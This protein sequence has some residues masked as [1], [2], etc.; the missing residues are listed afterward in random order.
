MNDHVNVKID[1]SR[2][3]SQEGKELESN[4]VDEFVS[5][6]SKGGIGP[7]VNRIIAQIPTIMLGFV[8]H[9]PLIKPRKIKRLIKC[10]D[11]YSF[12]DPELLPSASHSCFTGTSIWLVGNDTNNCN[13]TSNSV[14]H[15]Q[16]C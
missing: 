3:R 13:D 12:V 14:C 11:I 9:E 4:P 10:T 1:V 15:C 5:S 2:K 8:G 6:L 16:V 7:T